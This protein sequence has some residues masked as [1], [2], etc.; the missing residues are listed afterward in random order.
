MEQNEVGE[1]LHKLKAIFCELERLPQPTIAAI[2]GVALGGGFELSLCCDMRIG[3]PKTLVGLPETSLGI[4]PGAGGTQRLTKLIGESR[5]KALVFTAKRLGPQAALAMGIL[6]DAETL[7][8]ENVD[9]LGYQRALEW[10]RDILPNGP[11]AVRMAKKAI[12]LGGS[13]DASS[14]LDVEQLCYAHVIPTEDRMEGLRAFKE[15]RKPVYT[16]R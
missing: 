5:T 16:G 8:T 3:G 11:V 10:A 9:E 2:D 4:I 13:V 15:K 12:D 7:A 14:G 1:F 6:N